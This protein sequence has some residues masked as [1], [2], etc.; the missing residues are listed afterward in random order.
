GP[1]GNAQILV[2]EAA[3]TSSGSDGRFAFDFSERVPPRVR[4][5]VIGFGE[6]V[7]T[8]EV[9]HE[10]PAA[11]RRIEL[12]RSASLEIALTPPPGQVAARVVLHAEGDELSQ[13]AP[14]ASTSFALP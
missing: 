13:D 12:E 1:V 6:A 5:R 14:F 7:F 10:T 4:V 9:G 3:R 2:N 8:P 11:A